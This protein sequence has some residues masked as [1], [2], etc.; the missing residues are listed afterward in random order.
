MRL[1]SRR[2]KGCYFLAFFLVAFFFVAFFAFLATGSSSLQDQ[3]VQ[4]LCRRN[5][6]INSGRTK[7]HPQFFP[8]LS[9]LTGRRQALPNLT[10]GNRDLRIVDPPP[11][12]ATTYTFHACIVS[13]SPDS[14]SRFCI[15]DCKNRARCVRRD[16]SQPARQL[17]ER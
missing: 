16:A 1:D 12:T 11:S 9:T 14:A 6:A 3:Y 15:C 13:I 17:R 7:P 10:S 4:P 2:G 5:R 8:D